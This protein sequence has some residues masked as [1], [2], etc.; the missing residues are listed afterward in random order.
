MIIFTAIMNE[1]VPCIKYAFLARNAILITT[2]DRC[3][4]FRENI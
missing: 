2:I 4:S 3:E 1:R